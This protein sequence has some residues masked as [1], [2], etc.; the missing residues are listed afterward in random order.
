MVLS[1]LPWNPQ[2][3]WNAARHLLFLISTCEMKSGLRKSDICSDECYAKALS[4]VQ[5]LVPFV[6]MKQAEVLGMYF[7]SMT[8]L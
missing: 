6:L 1:F 7:L 5:D 8:D 3:A 2:S 4:H